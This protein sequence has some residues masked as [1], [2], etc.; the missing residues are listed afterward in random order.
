[1][2]RKER[3]TEEKGC[4]ALFYGNEVSTSSI[5]GKDKSLLPSN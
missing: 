1:M 5:I 4:Q 3:L 2:P